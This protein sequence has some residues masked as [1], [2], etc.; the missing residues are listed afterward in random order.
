V[1]YPKYL[2]GLFLLFLPT[3]GQSQMPGSGSCYGL[4]KGVTLPESV[5]V[6][7][8]PRNWK[9]ALR[10]ESPDL[11]FSRAP[12]S[13]WNTIEEARQSFIERME[14]KFR[15]VP[16]LT[17]VLNGSQASLL[18]AGFCVTK[19]LRSLSNIVWGCNSRA[20]EISI[21]SSDRDVFLG[22]LI[23]AG[24]LTGISWVDQREYQWG[25]HIV[26]YARSS[27]SEGGGIWIFDVSISPRPL[28]LAEWMRAIVDPAAPVEI[29]LELE[30]VRDIRPIDAI[31]LYEDWT[32]DL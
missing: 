28:T 2:M 1:N 23:A 13:Q 19:S 30:P 14:E 7:K 20:E 25:W 17:T 31:Q 24:N 29:D 8:R 12:R 18:M 32:R 15:S 6:K 16:D 9:A 4:L 10:Y 5:F 3:L 27:D 11:Y 26:P 22:R 21:F